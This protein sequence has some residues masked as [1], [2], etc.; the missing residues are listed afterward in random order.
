M[1]QLVN[2]HEQGK[3]MHSIKKE[4]NKFASELNI[5]ATINEELPCTLQA[6]NLK[7]KAK[8]EG[9]KKIQEK[10]ESKPLHGQ[11]PKRSQQADVDKDKTHQWLRGTGLKA[12]IIIIIIINFFIVGFLR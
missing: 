8:Q 1:L 7:K 5:E 9:L 6:K 4:S 2:I 11:Y 3:K 10:W 12:E